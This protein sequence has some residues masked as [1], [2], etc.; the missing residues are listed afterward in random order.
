[1]GTSAT[2]V[3]LSQQGA[4]NE[5]VKGSR[6]LVTGLATV[7]AAAT[8]R[9]ANLARRT[10]TIKNKTGGSTLYVGGQSPATTSDFEVLAGEALTMRVTSAIYAISAGTSNVNFE[11][12]QRA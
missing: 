8:L 12:E 6:N 11:E 10:I 1:M 2:N 4:L 3:D 5:L 7:T 9:A